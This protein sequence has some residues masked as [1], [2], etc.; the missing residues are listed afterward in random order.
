MMNGMGSAY[1]SPQGPKGNP[2]M[3][4]NGQRP[5]FKGQLYQSPGGP[6]MRPMGPNMSPYPGMTSIPYGQT[7]TVGA[8]APH[9]GAPLGPYP[10]SPAP[11]PSMGQTGMHVNQPAHILPQQPG[12][13]VVLCRYNQHTYT[14]LLAWHKH[15]DSHYTIII[16]SVFTSNLQ[17][18]SWKIFSNCLG[19]N[20]LKA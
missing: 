3:M 8:Q 6:G 4:P 20:I 16:I 10:G 14:P 7:P 2:A 17:T 19:H 13:H 15:F 11:H 12:N 1:M 5:P 18:K 9:N